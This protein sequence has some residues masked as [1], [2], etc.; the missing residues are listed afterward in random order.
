[1][2][3]KIK[4]K[5]LLNRGLINS[6]HLILKYIYAKLFSLPYAL[7]IEPSD[8][9][10][11]NCSICYTQKIKRKRNHNFLS[12]NEFKKIID[13]AKNYCVYINLWIAGEPLLNKELERMISYA[14]KK[15]IITL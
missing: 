8:L 5:T 13:N 15:N 7:M 6:G 9:C 10:N 3:Y 14:N 4:I 2:N 12:F 1:M 11:L